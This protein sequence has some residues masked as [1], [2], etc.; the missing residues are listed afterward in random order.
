MNDTSFFDRI[1][2]TDQVCGLVRRMDLR[3]QLLIRHLEEEIAQLVP[4]D[5]SWLESAL[6][7]FLSG[8]TLDA[9]LAT[10]GWTRED[11]ELNIWRPEALRR[12]AEQRFGPGVEEQF[13]KEGGNSDQV[14]YSMIRLQDAALAREV[15]I[16][17]EENEMSFSEAASQFGGGQES[18]HLGVIGPLKVGQI[19][20]IELREHIRNLQPGQ[21]Q[22]PVRLGDWLVL[23]KLEKITLSTFNDE[24][25]S[26]ILDSQLRRFLENRAKRIFD[27]DILEPLE[28][29]V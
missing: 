13:L 15:W 9:T 16:R 27:Q 22:P 17:I 25:R 18:S 29:D 4:V 3:A 12:F 24:T 28:Y 5:S 7:K 19:Y 23:L 20:P 26:K 14:V 8:N 10:H 6:P 1:F 2:T 11:L 21:V